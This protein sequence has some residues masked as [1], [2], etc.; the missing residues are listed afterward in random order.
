MPEKKQTILA[1]NDTES[2]IDTLLE[3]PVPEEEQ[4]ITAV[5]DVESN[6]DSLLE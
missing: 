2:D 3:I 6:I 1:M 5:D 4:T